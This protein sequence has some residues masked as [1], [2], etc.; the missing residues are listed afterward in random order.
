M[1]HV[2]VLF[3]REVSGVMLASL[4]TL[5]CLLCL[6]LQLQQHPGADI[7]SIRELQQAF[8]LAE[9]SYPGVT[10]DLLEHIVQKLKS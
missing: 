3:Q 5:F 7:N 1:V 8:E 2:C 10:D 4:M 9:V 6:V